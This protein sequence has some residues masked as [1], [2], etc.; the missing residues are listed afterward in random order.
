MYLEFDKTNEKDGYLKAVRVTTVGGDVEDYD[1]VISIKEINGVF[2]IDNT[3]HTHSHSTTTVSR[4][5]LYDRHYVEYDD[6]IY[7]WVDSN[8]ETVYE[9]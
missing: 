8:Y 9:K 1:P 6:D 2:Y 7:A 3:Y 4:I 5:E